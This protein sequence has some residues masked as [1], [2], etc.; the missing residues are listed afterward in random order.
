MYFEDWDVEKNAYNSTKPFI[1]ESFS[2]TYIWIRANKSKKLF[3]IFISSAVTTLING[4]GFMIQN[5]N[6]K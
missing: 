4:V 2:G 5:E 6:N 1:S 3:M